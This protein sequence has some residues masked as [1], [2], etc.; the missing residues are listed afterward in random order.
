MAV[1]ATHPLYDEHID[2]WI[3]CRHV[4]EGSDRVK[5]ANTRYLPRLSGQETSEYDKYVLRSFF[6]EATGRTLEA[7]SGAVFRKPLSIEAPD[8]AADFL[9]D[10]MGTGISLEDVARMAFDEVMTTGRFSV[11]ASLPALP[12]PVPRPY[13]VAYP[14][15]CFINW[16][17]SSNNQRLILAV[18]KEYYYVPRDEFS[19]EEK[20]Q[21]RVLSIDETGR[22]LV[23]TYRRQEGPLFQNEWTVFDNFYPG[24]RGESLR[25][26]PLFT[27][28]PSRP[29]VVPVK[30]PILGLVE[31]NLDHYRLM[32]D[33]RHGLHFCGLPTPVATGVPP[34]TVL[35]I[36]PSQAWILPDP[37]SSASMLEFTGQGLQPMESAIDRVTE[38]M[39]SLGARLLEGQ[40][41]AAEAAETHRLRQSGE[42]SVI[43]SVARNVGN[44][45]S[46]ALT[47]VWQWANP[48]N[49]EIKVALNTDL[50]EYDLDPAR[51]DSLVRAV[52][53]GMMSYDT[54]YHNLQRGE[55]ARPGISAEEE[56]ELIQ[57]QA[58]SA[59]GVEGD[60]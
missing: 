35:T 14:T 26:I 24:R 55:M 1:D 9:A 6:Y 54:F 25:E 31:A 17:Y 49:D 29:T 51:L 48:T 38:Y 50:L 3:K 11:M 15:E 2:K 60:D 28:T 42:E 53:A 58:P 36:G 27:A 41:K 45:L 23:R 19:S 44:T 22:Y 18:L 40:K 30:P 43:K 33:Y 5:K 59:R 34:D 10:P 7:M 52:Q 37:Q 32:A 8:N 4:A 20:E 16:R 13:L 56:R 21:Y 39:A 57:I 12:S 46:Q 47:Y